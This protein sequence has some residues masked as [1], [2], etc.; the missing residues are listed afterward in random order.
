MLFSKHFTIGKRLWFAFAFLIS[1]YALVLLGLDRAVSGYLSGFG[2]LGA[3]VAGAFYTLGATTPFAMVVVLELMKSGNAL[4]V[5]MF[6]CGAATAVDCYLFY[7]VRETLAKNSRKLMGY[8][9]KR[10]DGFRFAFP[11]AGFIVFGLPIPDEI[12]LALMEMTD[13]NLY[14]LAAVVFCAKFITLMALWSW[15]GG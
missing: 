11:F 14:K 12:G 13:I 5:A 3:A 9:H 4:M 8:M 7:A 10:F 6:A 2:M 15:L 1:S